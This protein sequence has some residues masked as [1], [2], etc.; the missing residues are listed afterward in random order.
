MIVRELSSIQTKAL[1]FSDAPLFGK[2]ELKGLRQ[3]LSDS[4]MVKRLPKLCKQRGGERE[5]KSKCYFSGSNKVSLGVQNDTPS[6][7]FLLNNKP[8][9]SPQN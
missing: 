2:G 5:S 6:Y 9:Q 1:D 8:T 7:L 3:M 4:S